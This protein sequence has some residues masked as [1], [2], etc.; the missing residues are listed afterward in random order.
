VV[1]LIATTWLLLADYTPD[2][3]DDKNCLKLADLHSAAVDYPKSGIPVST[4]GI[5][6]Q[7]PIKPDWYA[8]ETVD[9]DEAAEDYYT[10][11]R[12]LGQ[13]FRD[14]TLP[15]TI[16]ARRPKREDDVNL[17][18]LGDAM[19]SLSLSNIHLQDPIS[20]ALIL[21]L[22]ELLRE[23]DSNGSRGVGWVRQLFSTYTQELYFIC[24][25]HTLSLRKGSRL[26]EE[27]V[28]VG[29]ILAKTSQPR[30]RQDRMAQ[31]REYGMA[32]VNQVRD[33]I[34]DGNTTAL[35][36]IRRGWVA[37]KLSRGLADSDIFGAESFGVIAL[38]LILGGI[39]ALENEGSEP[40]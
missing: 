22:P 33:E 12:A 28:L 40:E 30:R 29:T 36:R 26:S 5:P 7:P 32:L 3:V 6:R 37:W 19:S 15:N 23:D 1:G 20:R 39:T 25:Q 38:G 9:A 8:P 10:S 21:R 11:Q 34:A 27:E 17:Q 2:F 35:L 14:I 16:S 31:M 24:R 13:L 18:A 4:Y